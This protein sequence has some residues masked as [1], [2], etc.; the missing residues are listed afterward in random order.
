MRKI[1]IDIK[2]GEIIISE[3]DK[4]IIKE[5]KDGSY[6]M[7]IK[8]DRNLK[9]HAKYWLL[10]DA[11]AFHFGNTAELWH[12]HYK[13]KFL[14]LEE[15]LLPSGKKILYPSSIAFDKLDQ[16]VFESYYNNIEMFL[17]ENGYNID[18]LMSSREI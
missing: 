3:I 13:A 17:N 4:K 16:L 1:Y 15:F 6:S 10:M 18:E 8:K 14:P 7:L 12:V 11:L 9:H 5:L 2:N